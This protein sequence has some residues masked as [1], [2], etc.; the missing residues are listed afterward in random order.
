M[1]NGLQAKNISKEVLNPT[2]HN[3]VVEAFRSIHALGIIHSDVRKEN[4]L[5]RA[6]NTVVII[7][8]EFSQ[9]KDV[10]SDQIALEEEEV[11]DLLRDL[12]ESGRHCKEDIAP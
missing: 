5:V 11:A 1:T 4:I 9:C 7:D 6:D 3:N 10:T 12:E 2:V 8:F